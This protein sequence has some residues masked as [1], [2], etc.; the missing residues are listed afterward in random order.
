MEQLTTW[1]DLR[2]NPEKLVLAQSHETGVFFG[3][4]L[5]RYASMELETTSLFYV[6]FSNE[7]E[8]REFGPIDPTKDKVYLVS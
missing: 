1:G 3:G 6:D 5:K 8:K 2:V 4:T 7:T